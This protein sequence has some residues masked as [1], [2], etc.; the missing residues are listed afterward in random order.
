MCLANPPTRLFLFTCKNWLWQIRVIYVDVLS[1]AFWLNQNLNWKW[2]DT[3]LY[4][5]CVCLHPSPPRK[6]ING[7]MSTEA[8]LISE[9]SFDRHHTSLCETW[10]SFLENCSCSLGGPVRRPPQSLY[11]DLALEYTLDRVWTKTFS[12]PLHSLLIDRRTNRFWWF[13]FIHFQQN[14]ICQ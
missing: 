5:S 9:A 7:L 2:F 12:D 4:K 10:I 14:D 11:V 8:G 6:W 1:S 3:H 13:P